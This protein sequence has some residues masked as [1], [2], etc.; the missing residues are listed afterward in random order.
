MAAVHDA[1]LSSRQRQTLTFW[2]YT[3]SNQ[4]ARLCRGRIRQ[5]RRRTLGRF[6]IFFTMTR[7]HCIDEQNCSKGVDPSNPTLHQRFNAALPQGIVLSPM[8]GGVVLERRSCQAWWQ[9]SAWL[10]T[11]LGGGEKLGMVFR[12]P[13]NTA[14]CRWKS[15]GQRKVQALP[16]LVAGSAS[17]QCNDSCHPV[18]IHQGRA[19]C[20]YILH[21]AEAMHAAHDAT[22]IQEPT[23]S[24]ND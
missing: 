4:V 19:S 24:T 5:G 18:S 12:H 7:R 8:Q 14:F 2:K 11:K 10:L 13:Y 20:M 3:S 21:S 17:L 22:Q 16:L 23:D 1:A 15:Y 9:A 6:C